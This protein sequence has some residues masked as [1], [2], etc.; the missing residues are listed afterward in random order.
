MNSDALVS[1]SAVLELKV[2]TAMFGI[3]PHVWHCAFGTPLL[4]DLQGEVKVVG[5]GGGGRG[6]GVLVVL[7]G[8]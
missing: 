3:A 2:Y 7:V 4:M 5:V 1:T 6:F 8:S